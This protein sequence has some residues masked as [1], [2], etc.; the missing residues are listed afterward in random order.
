MAVTSFDNL[1]FV[2]AVDALRTRTDLTKESLDSLR[3]I[4]RGPRGKARIQSFEA[5]VGVILDTWRGVIDT[6]AAGGTIREFAERLPEA[7]QGRGWRGETPYRTALV[8]NQQSFMAMEAGK[9]QQF[10]EMEVETW[11]FSTSDDELV[12]PIC[13][14]LDGHV[15]SMSDRRFWPPVHFGCRCVSEPLFGHE[16]ARPTTSAKVMAGIARLR[17]KKAPEVRAAWARTLY[18]PNSFR[19]DPKAFLDVPPTDLG[20]VPAEL[21]PVIKAIAADEGVEVKAA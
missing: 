2:E 5:R 10:T 17:G 19:W 9:F 7:L 18:R 20:R 3:L 11:K 14:R 8:F 12:C 6:L 15:F 4:A 21:L 16:E 13:G 1:P